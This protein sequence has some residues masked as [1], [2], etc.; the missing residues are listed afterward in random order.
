MRGP[1]P[2]RLARTGPSMPGLGRLYEHRVARE[3]AVSALCALPGRSPQHASTARYG[4]AVPAARGAAPECYR[5]V[6]ALL[7]AG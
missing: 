5:A 6:D 7:Y 4:R 1:F 2:A 3:R